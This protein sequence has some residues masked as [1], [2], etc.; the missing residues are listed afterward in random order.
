[1]RC[2]EFPSRVG[3]PSPNLRGRVA[4]RSS[5]SG[6][7]LRGRSAAVRAS[8][9]R[10]LPVVIWASRCVAE[11]GCGSDSAGGLA[12]YAFIV[13][14]PHTFSVVPP[15]THHVAP[16]AASDQPT[17]THPFLRTLSPYL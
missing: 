16:L 17:C 13:G 12:T 11:R 2:Y 9:A 5:Q 7:H 1:M 3:S 15:L 6:R 10:L 4:P 8:A 14:P